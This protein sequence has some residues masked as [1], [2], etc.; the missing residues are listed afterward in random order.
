VVE[1]SARA[2]A[3]A[4][5]GRVEIDGVWLVTTDT[6]HV[7][8]WDPAREQVSDWDLPGHGL[9]ELRDTEVGATM[10]MQGVTV[11]PSR[12]AVATLPAPPAARLRAARA[13][14]AR[15]WRARTADVDG[16]REVSLSCWRQAIDHAVGAPQSVPSRWGSLAPAAEAGRLAAS[17]RD[18][19]VRDGVLAEIVLRAASRREGDDAF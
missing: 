2:V 14:G 3:A 19:I 7:C 16:W 11:A 6:F 12:D 18:A 8:E 5:Q 4:A 1:R 9:A 13:A 15:S 17:L 10:V